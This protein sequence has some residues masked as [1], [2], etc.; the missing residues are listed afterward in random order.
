MNHNEIAPR[1]AAVWAITA[2]ILWSTAFV[3]IKAGLAY[4]KP[5]SFAG[6]RFMISGLLLFPFWAGKVRK[7]DFNVRSLQIL[8][9][10]AV[11]Q[12][13]LLYGFFYFAMTLVSGA[14]FVN[15]A[16]GPVAQ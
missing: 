7:R 8:L 12:T 13:F 5:F 1:K 2:C 6:I 10:V 9:K 11:L 14:V 4:S 16:A 15:K 3:A